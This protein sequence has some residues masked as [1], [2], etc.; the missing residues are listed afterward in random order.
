MN[1]MLRTKMF[2]SWK[3]GEKEISVGDRRSQK[4]VQVWEIEM[5]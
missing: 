2:L 3:Q 4:L 5:P 1:R